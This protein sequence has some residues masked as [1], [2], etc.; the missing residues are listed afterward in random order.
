MPEIPAGVHVDPVDGRFTPR[1][2]DTD[3]SARNP[4]D[5]DPVHEV[6]VPSL[7]IKPIYNPFDM[8]RRDG[9]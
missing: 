4:G 1:I 9:A 6:L 7:I 5:P 8:T 3:L 2:G